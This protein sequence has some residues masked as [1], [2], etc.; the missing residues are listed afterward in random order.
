ME[1][2]NDSLALRVP[3]VLRRKLPT[4]INSEVDIRFSNTTC[5]FG[6]AL[7]TNWTSAEDAVLMELVTEQIRQMDSGDEWGK[8]LGLR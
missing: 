1:E 4:K 7:T 5:M 6:E 3:R 8:L 2:A